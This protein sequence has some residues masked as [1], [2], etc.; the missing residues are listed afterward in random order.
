M[1]LLVIQEDPQRPGLLYISAMAQYQMNMPLE[2]KLI[3]LPYI[4]QELQF[5]D[6]PKFC[7]FP[8]NLQLI[9]TFIR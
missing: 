2:Y 9:C 1:R 3:F 8:L 7:Y 6:V 5:V 4:Y